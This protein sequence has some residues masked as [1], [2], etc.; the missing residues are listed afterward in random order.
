MAINSINSRVVSLS[1][2]RCWWISLL[3][4]NCIIM[5][6]SH[7]LKS[8]W[9]WPHSLFLT[10]KWQIILKQGSEYDVTAFH[11]KS[12]FTNSQELGKVQLG[13]CGL[14]MWMGRV[15]RRTNV[16]KLGP[17]DKLLVLRQAD[18]WQAVSASLNTRSAKLKCWPVS[19]FVIE[20]WTVYLFQRECVYKGY[21]DTIWG[22]VR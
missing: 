14:I 21:E 13:Q 5:A 18:K 22:N 20:K 3:G 16:G 1:R 8:A 2:S 12:S 6:N 19:M 7:W 11:D 4:S 17:S 9:L 15:L 10:H